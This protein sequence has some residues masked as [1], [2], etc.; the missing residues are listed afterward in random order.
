MN[1]PKESPMK[2]LR[3]RPGLVMSLPSFGHEIG[4][5]AADDVVVARMR[6]DEVGIV[7]PEVID[8]LAGRDLDLDLVDE[9]ALVHQLVIDLN[10]GDLGEG[11]GQGLQLVIVDAED[12]RNRTDLHALE[13]RRRLDEP[14][15]LGHLLVFAQGRRL[16][17]AIDPFLCCIDLLG[18]AGRGRDD[19]CSTHSR[20]RGGD[21]RCSLQYVTTFYVHC[22]LP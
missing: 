15:H 12:F 14:F 1:V 2:S 16:K 3:S 19:R 5:R 4:E 21:R 10:A 9:Q 7:H 8:R 6:A 11:L 17:L 20:R 22:F 13:R 18:I